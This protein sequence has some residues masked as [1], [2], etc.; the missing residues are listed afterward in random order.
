M[1]K[2]IKEATKKYYEQFSLSK[3][4]LNSLESRVKDSKK[5]INYTRGQKL[6]TLAA[7]IVGVLFLG[8]FVYQN[9]TLSLK[10]ELI[11]EIAY[12]HKKNLNPEIVSSSFKQ[13]R[14]YFSKL[15]FL[16]VHS[17]ALP[18]AEWELIGGRYCSLKNKLAAQLR[19]RDKKSGDVLTWY[20]LSNKNDLIHVSET[21]DVFK[22]GMRVKI[23]EENGIIHGLAGGM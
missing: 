19:L 18:A 21:Y 16:P 8:L 17:K 11:E 13:V 23:W 22:D 20:Q 3:S 7:S 12:N 2:P 14:Q 10:Q 9:N 1:K 4:Q 5:G 6:A 15:D